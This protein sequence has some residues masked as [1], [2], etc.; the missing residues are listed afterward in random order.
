MSNPIEFDPRIRKFTVWTSKWHVEYMKYFDSAED[1]GSFI[2][3]N[4]ERCIRI[5]GQFDV[6]EIDG[7]AT[8]AS[9]FAAASL[10]PRTTHGA[11]QD[12]HFESQAIAPAGRY[13]FIFISAFV[14]A[15]ISNF[16]LNKEEMIVNLISSGVQALGVLLVVMIIQGFKR[17]IRR[18]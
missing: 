16:A 15:V 11:K 1:A 3:A 12:E 5:P 10:E 18:K 14:I 9:Q 4:A 2:R 7:W 17:L 13:L 6:G 8:K